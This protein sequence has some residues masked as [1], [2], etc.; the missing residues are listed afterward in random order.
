MA[1]FFDGQGKA[2]SDTSRQFWGGHG[3]PQAPYAALQHWSLTGAIMTAT[4][5]ERAQEEIDQLLNDPETPMS[6]DRIWALADAI[7]AAGCDSGD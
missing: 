7:A 4:D 2:R 3:A 5:C 1:P 6:P